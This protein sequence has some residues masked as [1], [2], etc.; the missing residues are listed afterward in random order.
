M[1]AQGIR[2][3]V[4]VAGLQKA[5]AD[6]DI[7]QQ[8]DMVAAQIRPIKGSPGGLCDMID[9]GFV[10]IAPAPLLQA[11]S[12][13]ELVDN[14]KNALEIPLKGFRVKSNQIDDFFV[15]DPPLG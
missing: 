1:E 10:A 5:A 4:A 11:H 9:G 8:L 14:L 7:D 15:R 2:D 6:A 12:L 3:H 13:Q